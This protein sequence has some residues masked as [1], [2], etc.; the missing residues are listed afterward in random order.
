MARKKVKLAWIPNDSARRATFRKRR[1]G[2]MKK[3]EELSVLC[4]VEACGIVY[5]PDEPQ[6]EVWPSKGGARRVLERFK[7]MPVMEQSKKMMDQEGFTRHQVMKLQDQLRKHERENQELETAIVMH[8]CLCSSG[9]QQA[10]LDYMNMEE[11]TSLA[12]MVEAKLKAVHDRI[13]LISVQMTSY[14]N[15][16]DASSHQLTTE[17]VIKMDANSSTA[18]GAIVVHGH[19]I[20][21][22]NN[23]N[24]NH[25]NHWEL[26]AA[27]DAMQ[28]QAWY[29]T[30]TTD[31]HVMNPNIPI[32]DP[33]AV[34]Y[35]S[36]EEVMQQ[37]PPYPSNY[38]VGM[39]MT[40]TNLNIIDP[41]CWI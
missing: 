11:L 1:K 39:N 29:T 36:G 15:I 34:Y 4:N 40:M 35:G 19:N 8:K 30:T 13:E 9:D 6:P 41:P 14:H 20:E 24:N 2:L 12:M 21:D 16:N 32:N 38:N 17:H 25:H 10:G 26:A 22:N 23:N 18:A 27:M 7:S 31:H 37:Q 28:K 3:L 5:G 33:A